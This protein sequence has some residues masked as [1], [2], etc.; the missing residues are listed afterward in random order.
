[1]INSQLSYCNLIWGK[2][3]QTYINKLFIAQKR[4]IRIFKNR[5][6]TYHTNNDFKD[7]GILKVNEI[8][9]SINSP[10]QLFHIS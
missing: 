7:L 3:P 4:I 9:K 10:I 6:R 5:P 2:A 1:M 8:N